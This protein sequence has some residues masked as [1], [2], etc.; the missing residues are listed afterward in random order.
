[1]Q[2]WLLHSGGGTLQV[3][4]DF[5]PFSSMLATMTNLNKRA[6]T[7]HLQIASHKANIQ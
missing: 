1:M 7:L 6:R 3:C 4:L 5:I 2:M